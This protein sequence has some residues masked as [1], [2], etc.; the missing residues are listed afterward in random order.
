MPRRDPRT[1]KFV[2]GGRGSGEPKTVV[3]DLA[4]SILAADLAGGQVNPTVSGDEAELV[5]FTPL[6][7]SDEV[8]VL[9]AMQGRAFLAGPTTATAEGSVLL[10]YALSRDFASPAAARSSSYWVSS[11]PD[12]T[13]GIVDINH[14]QDNDTSEFWSS[15]LRAEPSA[16]D[17]TTGTALGTDI[18][19][20]DIQWVWDDGPQ[21][22]RDD[23]IVVPHNW[24]VDGVDDHA[25]EFDIVMRFDGRIVEG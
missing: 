9:D 7:D 4:S 24:E 19:R 16:R 20:E 18:D 5:D 8:F 6:L 17:T 15:Q 14:L 2:S 12:R 21:F 11:A 10:E 13:S 3:A 25:V 22:D 1:G 23:E